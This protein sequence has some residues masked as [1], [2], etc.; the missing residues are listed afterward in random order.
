MKRTSLVGMALVLV[1]I[2]CGRYPAFCQES[3]GRETVDAKD[4]LDRL[5]KERLEREA[6]D[7]EKRPRERTY[8]RGTT[9]MLKNLRTEDI[10][11]MYIFGLDIR[12]D[13]VTRHRLRS[14]LRK[15]TIKGLLSLCRAAR[16]FRTVGRR[17]PMPFRPTHALAVKPVKGE[18]FEIWY[19]DGFHEPFGGLESRA[20]K[21]ALYAAVKTSRCTIIHFHD[22]KPLGV[23]HL[24]VG[25]LGNSGGSMKLSSSFTLSEKGQMMLFLKVKKDG[26]EVLSDA[27]PMRYGQVKAYRHDGAGHMIVLLHMP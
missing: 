14:P 20:L 26:K 19:G 8:R 4:A 27:Q 12:K 5:L 11:E 22:G 3:R 16:P 18:P 7:R 1:L 23:W 10:E 2:L 9:D 6:A 25:P 21:Q 15:S 24:R 13:K 17:A